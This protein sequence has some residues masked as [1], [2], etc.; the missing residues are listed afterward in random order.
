M[1]ICVSGLYRLCIVDRIAG[2]F[3]KSYQV[4]NMIFSVGIL[5][6][7]MTI[8]SLGM[9]IIVQVKRGLSGAG[10]LNIVVCK[11]K[12][13]EKRLPVLILKCKGSDELLND[14]NHSFRLPISLR[15]FD[16]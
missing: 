9:V 11:L 5:R 7:G 14:F 12:G 3:L 10:L 1:S 6:V 15:V 2:C 13:G 8:C 4:L 16:R